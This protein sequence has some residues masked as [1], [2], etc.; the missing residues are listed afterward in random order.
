M[1]FAQNPK[2]SRVK[3]V[4]SPHCFPSCSEKTQR[5]AAQNRNADPHRIR[6]HAA[7]TPRSWRTRPNVASRGTH[8]ALK[9]N[10]F[11]VQGMVNPHRIPRV[12]F[13]DLA[14][15]SMPFRTESKLPPPSTQNSSAR[16]PRQRAFED[17]PNRMRGEPEMFPRSAQKSMP[18]HIKAI[19]NPRIEFKITPR[20]PHV[21]GAKKPMSLR[22]APIVISR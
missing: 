8:F 3:C 10:V 17:M 20:R 9:P 15:M 21:H 22:A 12:G 5:H 16:R 7:Q 2:S 11:C 18:L 4:V 13:E 6:D 1:T 14:Q 19:V